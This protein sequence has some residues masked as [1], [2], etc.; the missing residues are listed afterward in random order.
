MT[1]TDDARTVDA[2]AVTEAAVSTA[3]DLEP[4]FQTL[5]AGLAALGA[6]LSED[7]FPARGL[8]LLRASGFW[9]A[10]G[11]TVLPGP[12]ML[13]L[14]R[15][16]GRAS[17]PLGRLF[18]GHVNALAL[19]SAYGSAEQ[20]AGAAQDIREG[21][22]FG[23]W[24][25]EGQ[26]GV[27]LLGGSAPDTTPLTLQGAKT[28]ASGGFQVTRPLLPV[29]RRGERQLVLLRADA[30]ESELR[31]VPGSW[32]PLGM[33]A[34][35]SVT[36]DFTGSRVGESDL[37]GQ[38]GDYYRQPMFSAG[39]L[40]FCAVQQGGAERL[41]DEVRGYLHRLGRGHDEVQMLRFA[42]CWTALRGAALMLAEGERLER[43]CLA[44]RVSEARLLAQVDAVRLA[45]EDA[46]LALLEASER[47]VGARGLLEPEPFSRLV[48]D[49]R[50]YLRQPAPDAA[51]LRLG[52]WVLNDWT[53]DD[54]TPDDWNPED[55]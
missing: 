2:R 6:G 21:R 12:A 16:V 49:L 8:D 39:A 37:I 9:G 28:F 17:L 20:R 54:W 42:G 11:E 24:N 19:I 29:D 52:Q 47:A 36:L 18:E 32:Q 46:C 55:D 45:T 3:A 15:L 33:G 43:A 7:Q 4:L 22:L 1:S 44:G 5:S 31:A 30:P 26:D 25:T 51:R 27:Q 34:T 50:M 41:L 35:G 14:M 48:R 40:R 10:G 23:V 38:P 13:R 53:P